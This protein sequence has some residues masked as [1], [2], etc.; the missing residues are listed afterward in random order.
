MRQRIAV[1]IALL[2]FASA[3][4]AE[5]RHYYIAAEDVMWD[6][7]PSGRNLVHGGGAIPEPWAGH[8][9][10]SKTRYIEYADETFRTKKEQPEWLGVLGPIIRA[11][12]GDNVVVNFC[13]HSARGAF[14]M[15]PHGFR[16]TKDNEG[17]HYVGAGAGAEVEPG[18][19]FTYHWLADE[20]SGPGPADPSS[21]VW[22]YHSHIDEPA[23]TNLGL[24]GPIVVTRKGFAR[25]DGRPKDIDREFVAAFFIFNEEEG[26]EEGLMH[27]ING[28]IFGNVSF[29]AVKGEKIRWYLLGMGNEIDI[30]T[31]HWHGKTLRY[32]NRNT[33][34]IELLPG[35]MA[36]ADMTADNPGTWL[37]H[38]HVSDHIYAGMITTWTVVDTISRPSGR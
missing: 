6:F 5:T 16:Y 11:E 4:I 33:D 7:A 34:V 1:L 17:A 20:G 31:P 36:T 22:W 27:S 2:L 18:N 21:L 3:A 29:V 23:E 30:H 10:W 32:Q 8:T 35:S 14:G 12:V 9:K 38:C 19:C 24:L 28:R 26:E 37:F 13:N 25:P 15:H